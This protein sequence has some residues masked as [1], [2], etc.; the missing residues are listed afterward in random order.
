MRGSNALLLFSGSCLMSITGG[1]QHLTG[2][3]HSVH[4]AVV[5]VVVV[6]WLDMKNPHTFLI[7]SKETLLQSI[8]RKTCTFICY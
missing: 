5:V 4:D 2:I 7:V 8:S 3:S 6:Q 1:A